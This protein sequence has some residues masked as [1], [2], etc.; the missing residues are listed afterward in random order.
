MHLR[1]NNF[2]AV[3]QVDK[4]VKTW[5]KDPLPVLKELLEYIITRRITLTVKHLAG[6]QK[7]ITD[8]KS[9]V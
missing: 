4:I 6:V 1:V 8:Q 2:I 7:T 5:S 9:C 3:A